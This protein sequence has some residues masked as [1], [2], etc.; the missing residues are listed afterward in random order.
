[1]S[2]PTGLVADVSFNRV[3]LTIKER[4]AV[5]RDVVSGDNALRGDAYL[6]ML[7]STD[8]SVENVARNKAYRSRAVWYPATQFTLEGLVGLAFHRDPVTELPTQLEYLLKDCDGLGVS[9]YQQSQATLNNNLAVGRH[10]L[11]VDWSEALGHPVIKAYH[12]ESIIN[13]R[14][15]IV[16][17][18]ASLCMIVLEEEAEE[19]DGE[20]GIVIVKQ[21]R[22]ITR[23]EAGN[24]QVRLWREDTGVTKT[25]RLVALGTVKNVATGEEDIIDAVELRSKGKVLTDIPFTFIG[26]NNNDANIDPAPLY[27]LAQLNLAHFRNSADYEDSVFFCGQVQPWISGLTEQ[28]R[29]FMQNPYV[30]DN[31]G[32]RRYTGQKMYIGSR[33]PILLPQGAAFGMEQAQPNTLAADAMVHKEAQMI[34]VGARMIEGTK[35]N[36]TATGENNDREAT[37]SVLSLCVSNVS[38]AYQRAIGFCAAFMDMPAEADYADAFKIQQDFVQ[39]QAN[40]QLMAELIKSW[41]SGLLAKNDVR[42]FYRRL[43]L[44]ATERSNEDIDKDVEEEEPLGMMGVPAPGLPGVTPPGL[45]ATAAAAAAGAGAGGNGAAKPPTPPIKVVPPAPPERRAKARAR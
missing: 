36:K 20:W 33:S 9:L 14:Y 13:W 2:A 41:Q 5:V 19:E 8:A 25:K 3:P 31:N 45:A 30:L 15:D 26:S 34:A 28:W 29:D 44:I 23:N 16:D 21:W 10:G 35:A 11:F 42:D 18:K 27:G 43:G 7:N 22:E 4:W 17:G 24:V 12:A 38:E 32:E 37:T 6:P 1:M 39:L 40:P